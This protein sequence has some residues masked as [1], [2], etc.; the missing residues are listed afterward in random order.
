[1]KY[2][3][4]SRKDK[5]V[6]TSPQPISKREGQEKCVGDPPLRGGFRMAS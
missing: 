2:F 1:M 5:F 6:Q 4:L 3:Q